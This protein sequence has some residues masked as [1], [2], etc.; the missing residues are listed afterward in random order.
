MTAYMRKSDRCPYLRPAAAGV[1]ESVSGRAISFEEICGRFCGRKIVESRKTSRRSKIKSYICKKWT[2]ENRSAA[3]RGYSGGAASGFAACDRSHAGALLDAAVE[4][5]SQNEG[6]VI[7]GVVCVVC[8]SE[9][10][11]LDD[12]TVIRGFTY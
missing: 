8:A 7:V 2:G 12:G 3:E 10:Y 4:A 11:T 9:C 5:L 1:C 6:E